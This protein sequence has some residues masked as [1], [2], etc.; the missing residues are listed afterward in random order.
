MDTNYIP[1]I[2]YAKVHLFHNP[3]P[4]PVQVPE[5]ISM[6]PPDNNDSRWM[7][8]DQEIALREKI[9]DSALIIGIKPITSQD[10]N[11]EAEYI[12]KNS[13]IE[14]KNYKNKILATATKNLMTRFLKENMKMT[15]KDIRSLQI[16][17]LFQCNKPNSNILYIQ[18]AT[19]EDISL[20]TSHVTNFTHKQNDNKAPG[21][22]I[23][24]PQVLFKR[25]QYCEKLLWKMRIQNK[26]NLQTN[27][28]LGKIDFILRYKNKGDS[29]PWSEVPII[30]IPKDAP[31]PDLHLF[32]EQYQPKPSEYNTP[33]P[34]NQQ[35]SEVQMVLSET[36]G[37]VSKQLNSK[38][39][40]S[41]LSE[42]TS[43]H[44]TKTNRKEIIPNNSQGL[45]IDFDIN[46]PNPSQISNTQQPSNL[47]TI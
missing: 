43:Q 22:V 19:S 21:T 4:R 9:A 6:T 24:I 28:R 15:M 39:Q 35:E 11:K 16:T 5:N 41:P 30:L 44:K 1:P 45:E 27:L 47:N 42:D 13:A 3:K 40:L 14:N 20:I 10:I 33:H 34:S 37:S 12:I 38:H 46:L 26:G 32:K 29:T 8:D 2:A 36:Q 23:H 7:D 18:C 25:Y 17:Q 31:Y